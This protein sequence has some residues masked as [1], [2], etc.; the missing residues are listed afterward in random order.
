MYLFGNIVKLLTIVICY[1]VTERKEIQN[2]P[3]RPQ[4]S[5]NLFLQRQREEY[6]NHASSHYNQVRDHKQTLRQ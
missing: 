3:D 2:S 1:Y 4:T 6:Q 5:L